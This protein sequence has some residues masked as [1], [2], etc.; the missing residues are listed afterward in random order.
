MQHLRVGSI[1]NI[2]YNQG[3]NGSVSSTSGATVTHITPEYL[4]VELSGGSTKR[5]YSWS[6]I[7]YVDVTQD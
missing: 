2:S 5:A 6:W 7:A 1:V 3:S 4:E